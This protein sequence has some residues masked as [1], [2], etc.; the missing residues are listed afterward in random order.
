MDASKRDGEAGFTL[1]E[2]LCV[3]ALLGLTAGLVVVNLPQPD[4]KFRTEVQGVTTVLNVAARQ[5]I[6]DGKTRGFE[7]NATQLDVLKY[8]GEWTADHQSIFTDVSGLNLS[9][10]NQEIDLR[11][12]ERNKRRADLP[13]LVHFD[14]TGNVTPF[15][16][17]LSGDDESFTIEPDEHGRIVMKAIP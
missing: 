8:D 10:E 12:R 16:L 11:V 4:P 3:V 9:V 2:V 6:I 5:S 1:I 14:A 15:T 13:P 7:I 17:S